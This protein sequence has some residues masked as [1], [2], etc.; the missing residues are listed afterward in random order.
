MKI[1]SLILSNFRNHANTEIPFDDINVFVGL[2]AAGKS[3]IKNAVEYLL[4]GR[5][6]GLTDE[7]GRGA[8]E[9]LPRDGTDA[10]TV[11]AV[12]DGLGTVSRS[13]AGGLSVEG[14]GGPTKDQQAVLNNHLRASTDVISAVVNTGRF[15]TMSPGEQ[16]SMLFALLGLSFDQAILLQH[17]PEEYTSVFNR[18]YPKGL[19]GGAEVFDRLDKIFRDERRYQKKVLKDLEAQAGAETKDSDLPPGAWEN[20][21]T[22]K[23]QLADLKK[24]RD[25]LLQ[26]RTRTAVAG[27]QRK[28]IQIDIDALEQNIPTLEQEEKDLRPVGDNRA[29]ANYSEN[30]TERVKK[31]EQELESARNWHD[32]EYKLLAEFQGNKEAWEKLLQTIKADARCPLGPG[33]TC[34]ADRE[35]MVRQVKAD[36]AGVDENIKKQQEK[37]DHWKQEVAKLKGDLE[38]A[39]VELAEHGQKLNQWQLKVQQL[40]QAKNQLQKLV[41]DLAQLDDYDPDDL[42]QLEQEIDTLG[43]RIANG[44]NLVQQL[45]V[46]AARRQEREKLTENLEKTRAEV[47]ALEKL[48]VLFGPKGLRQEL[49]QAKLGKLQ[50]RADERMQLLT[51]GKYRVQFSTEDKDGFS[52]VVY[53]GD[54]PKKVR[55]LSTSEKLR[56]GVVMAD[57]LNGLTGLG[58]LIVDD[59]EMLD[60]ANKMALISMLLK[61]REKYGTI[62]VLSAIGE[63]QPRNPGVPGLAMWLV[64]NG[65]VQ[66]VPASA[67]A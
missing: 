52:L 67:A 48:V 59:A 21:E 37:V 63:T 50:A 33:I 53:K 26:T 1:N 43:Q 4:T 38:T 58:L 39:R 17:I 19:A 45:A 44:D 34:T 61:V 41:D 12:I 42:A 3:S 28:I 11:T 10:A 7:A 40:D 15:L 55:Q 20:R 13:T 57:V 66:P 18:L 64:E 5:C 6:S 35:E 23:K 25:E 51:G 29:E 2:N 60:P 54:V 46:E 36:L 8:A 32:S 30:L 22:I 62:I 65:T 31:L 14:L 49:L 16:K 56:L 47:Q 9:D 27:E 24:D